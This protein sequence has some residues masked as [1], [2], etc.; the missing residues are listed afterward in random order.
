MKNYESQIELL[1]YQIK[2]MK[3]II[4][5]DDYPYFMY[6]LDH[7]I[8]ENQSR[9]FNDILSILNLRQKSNFLEYDTEYPGVIKELK[10]KISNLNIAEEKLFSGDKPSY[11]EFEQYVNKIFPEHVNPKYLLMS[12]EGQNIYKELSTFLLSDSENK[13]PLDL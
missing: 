11:N 13:S 4:G 7:D 2:L 8:S 10:E 12:M 1:K 5:G 6:L 9:L 3:M